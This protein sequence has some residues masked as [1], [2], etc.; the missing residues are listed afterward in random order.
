VQQILTC[1]WQNQQ[2]TVPLVDVAQLINKK[3]LSLQNEFDYQ[4]AYPKFM[5]WYGQYFTEDGIKTLMADCSGTGLSD[6]ELVA[7][8][9]SLKINFQCK[10]P[11]ATQPQ[12]FNIG[13]GLIDYDINDQVHQS[14]IA[15]LKT[16]QIGDEFFGHFF[17]HRNDNKEELMQQ[18]NACLEFLDFLN[19][20]FLSSYCFS[21]N[22]LNFTP[23]NEKIAIILIKLGILEAN[24]I[25]IN[26]VISYAVRY[27]FLI[28]LET[29]LNLPPLPPASQE[30]TQGAI[31]F[32]QRNEITQEHF[33]A[34]C[35]RGLINLN[36]DYSFNSFRCRDLVELAA[37]L[38][39]F[40]FE[41]ASQEVFYAITTVFNAMQ[42]NQPIISSDAVMI[43]LL[44]RNLI[45]YRENGYYLTT[46]DF[47][48]ITQRLQ[49][50]LKL[51]PL[52]NDLIDTISNNHLSKAPVLSIEYN[53]NQWWYLR[54]E[55]KV[56]HLQSARPE[57]NLL[58]REKVPPQIS[59]KRK[60]E[61]PDNDPLK[62]RKVEDNN[63]TK[64]VSQMFKKF[65][66]ENKD[67]NLDTKE[68]NPNPQ[69]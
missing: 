3:W 61:T 68:E 19:N 36:Q 11:Y 52:G 22:K 40:P 60:L 35:Q 66:K 13:H 17:L 56:K 44:R 38:K 49:G 32:F 55:D 16:L 26:G 62:K 9:T 6:I 57:K 64:S 41:P 58:E 51:M 33:Y 15:K 59:R 53:E 50:Y 4:T 48:T 42:Q 25:T 43:E 18:D 2:Y 10:K 31:N 34:L 45:E 29:H 28:S 24:P 8:S 12:S 54:S 23:S 14:K 47:L 7:L 1:L 5:E 27:D 39:G 46:N 67:S 63:N 20:S 65:M 69:L 21:Q 30:L 37:N